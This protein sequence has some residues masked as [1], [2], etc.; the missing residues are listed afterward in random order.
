MCICYKYHT[1]SFK[2]A[3][4]KVLHRLKPSLWSVGDWRWSEPVIM[5]STG[6]SRSIIPQNHFII[7][8]SKCQTFS[9]DLWN[10][11]CLT[12]KTRF[13]FLLPWGQKR[14]DKLQFE[15]FLEIT[16]EQNKVLK[17]QD[18]LVLPLLS[19]F[20]H[21]FQSLSVGGCRDIGPQ[22]FE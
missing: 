10:Y 21:I 22:S 8:I 12:Y 3:W 17:I 7:S 20:K 6:D 14:R 16:T 18:T 15:L 1:T 5:V 13:L 11:H 2:K 19:S 9:S 4:T